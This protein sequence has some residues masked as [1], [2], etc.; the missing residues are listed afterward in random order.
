MTPSMQKTSKIKGAS[1]PALLN[2]I[3]TNTGWRSELTSGKAEAYY[4]L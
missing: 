4:F 1:E 3:E 2:A